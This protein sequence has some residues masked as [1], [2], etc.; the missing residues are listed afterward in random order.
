MPVLSFLQLCAIVLL[1]TG[2][3]CLDPEAG[4]AGLV[5]GEMTNASPSADLR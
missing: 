3:A 1:V 5:V 2:C 4:D